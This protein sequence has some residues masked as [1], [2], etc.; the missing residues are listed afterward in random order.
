MAHAS[1]DVDRLLHDTLHGIDGV[2]WTPACNAYEDE[3]G[4]H[5]EAS[6]P[7]LRKEDIEIIV[8]SGVLTVKGEGKAPYPDES[9]QYFVR[10][11]DRGPFSRSFR[12]P[13]QVDVDKVVAS[14]H[15][16][17]L[18]LTLPKHEEAKPRRIEIG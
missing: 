17:F 3:Q 2:G 13:K 10:E 12:L 5:L 7:G 15:D 8:E 11:I 4:F 16:G 6:L 9:R 18:T 1:I 14:Y